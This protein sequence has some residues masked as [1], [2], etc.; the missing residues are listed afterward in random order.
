MNSVSE[1]NLINQ[2]ECL[3]YF[4]KTKRHQHTR[5]PSLREM[6]VRAMMDT[7]EI[8]ESSFNKQISCINELPLKHQGLFNNS[9]EI[10]DSHQP[11]VDQLKPYYPTNLH[12][13]DDPVAQFSDMHERIEEIYQEIHGEKSSLPQSE[14]L[15]SICIE[16]SCK[17]LQTALQ[18]EINYYFPEPNEE[19]KK[20]IEIVNAEWTPTKENSLEFLE[21][22]I[23]YIDANMDALFPNPAKRPPSAASFLLLITQT[24]PLYVVEY[25]LNPSPFPP[26]DPNWRIGMFYPLKQAAKYNH[27]AIAKLLIEKGAEVNPPFFGTKIAPLYWAVHNENLDL[28]SLLI[29]HKARTGA[30]FWSQIVARG[31]ENIVELLLNAGMDI[32]TPDSSEH[33]LNIPVRMGNIGMV[34]FLLQK[35]ARADPLSLCLA[36]ECRRGNIANLLLDFGADIDNA[37]CV[38]AS[39]GYAIAVSSLLEKG[40]NPNLNSA[41]GYSFPLHC[42]ARNRRLNV[43][44]QLLDAGADIHALD[45]EGN[46]LLHCAVASATLDTVRDAYARNSAPFISNRDLQFIK[47]LVEQGINMHQFNRHN[48]T[49]F[50][51]AFRHPYSFG[52]KIAALLIQL[53][54]ASTYPPGTEAM[55]PLH[56]AVGL[57]NSSIIQTAIDT[58]A[59]INVQDRLG[60]TPLHTAIASGNLDMATFLMQNGADPSIP[61]H[62]GKTPV[63]M[64]I[65]CGHLLLAANLV[66]QDMSRSHS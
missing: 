57:G 48:S 16:L 20:L 9:V 65:E 35:G 11:L 39:H 63:R 15:E 31:N 27:F 58:G 49:P 12:D 59:N 45:H 38:A 24:T 25:L 36:L 55:S 56:W 1:H 66:G 44:R 8:Q 53:G 54:A 43:T 60:Y 6:S 10:S 13:D 61:D 19:Q 47:F 21:K 7:P 2:N 23:A 30:G 62:D 14:S 26:A 32:N 33:I 22:L 51:E 28:I 52:E 50:S 18:T 5:I 4:K 46:N 40:A 3:S 41:N 29:E 42:A 64:A 34:R 17:E 37:L